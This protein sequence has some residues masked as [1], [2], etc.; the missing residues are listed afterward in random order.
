MTSGGFLQSI[1][2]LASRATQAVRNRL[3][4]RT[5][6]PGIPGIPE[7]SRGLPGI[8]GLSGILGLSGIPGMSRGV[9]TRG[10]PVR[11]MPTT[12]TVRGI[13]NKLEQQPIY[14]KIITLV[15]LSLFI[16]IFFMYIHKKDDAFGYD[17]LQKGLIVACIVIVG[18]A[19]SFY[20]KYDMIDFI[21]SSQTNILCFFF[22]ISYSSLTALIT[23][24]GFFG[25][26]FS[27]F[28]IIFV[29]QEHNK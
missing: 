14:G 25:N 7:L 13:A 21:I 4:P 6:P 27:I 29:F 23:P 8:P 15:I 3:L 28:S 10:V 1:S 18:I 5:T 24:S 20:L 9:P 19:L 11:G 16:G 22:L 17:S 2:S 26:F 12:S